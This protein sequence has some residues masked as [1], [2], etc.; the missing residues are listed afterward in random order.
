MI[1]IAEELC[2][3]LALSAVEI[4]GSVLIRRTTDEMPMQPFMR[5]FPEF[6]VIVTNLRVR[7]YIVMHVDEPAPNPGKMC[8]DAYRKYPCIMPT[9]I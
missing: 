4:A 1:S 8:F 6:P 3:L 9:H 2:L 7:M 5:S